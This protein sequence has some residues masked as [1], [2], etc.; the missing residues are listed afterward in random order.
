MNYKLLLLSIIL[1]LASCSKKITIEDEYI[2]ENQNW[3]RFNDLEFDFEIQSTEKPYKIYLIFEF[4][5]DLKSELIRFQSQINSSD[6]DSRLSFI[7]EKI[8][9]NS[10]LDTVI[11]NPHRFFNTAE[12]YKL[13]IKNLSH[14]VDNH[15]FKS[16]KLKIE[17][18]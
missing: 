9:K 12:N 4:N 11:I 14:K 2:F 1:A 6:G 7:E 8:D 5:E 13:L 10:N 15:G 16:V 18:L 3:H 17:Q